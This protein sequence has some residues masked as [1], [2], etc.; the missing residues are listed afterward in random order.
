MA[1]GIMANKKQ[2]GRN[3]VTGSYTE[4]ISAFVAYKK[5]CGFKYQNAYYHLR[6]FDAFCALKENEALA[7]QQL[8]DSW[9]LKRGNE[10]PNTRAS[11][12][13]PISVFGKYLTSIGHP[14]AF[15]IADDVAKRKAPKPPYL[16]S[17]DDIDL[18]FSAC[19][20]LNSDEDGLSSHVVL[21][22]AFLFMHC[23][24]VRTCELKI[25]KWA[26]PTTQEYRSQNSEVRI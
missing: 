11:R 23:I 10:H 7:P 5:S 20:K 9:V 24:G 13:G 15:I 22:A 25:L 26:T 4:E 17:E 1:T 6:L 8:A 14:K 2:H 19:T 21:P 18:F 12:I 16:F 3:Y